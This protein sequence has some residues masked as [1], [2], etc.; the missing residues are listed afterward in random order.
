MNLAKNTLVAT[1][2][3]LSNE[4]DIQYNNQLNFRNHCYLRIAYDV[5][6]KNKWDLIIK[7]PFTKY[8]NDSQL[9]LV[10]DLL[11]FYKIDT[12][13]LLQ[14]N[15]KSLKYRKNTN[16]SKIDSSISLF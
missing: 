3:K 2:K 7:K 16:L 12:I 14:D 10:I 4:L 8:A 5:T 1:I 13:K 9:Q 15:E 11:L 6:V